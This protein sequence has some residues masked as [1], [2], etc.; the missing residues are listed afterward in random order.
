MSYEKNRSAAI[1]GVICGF[2]LSVFFNNYAPGVLGNETILYTAYPN[3]K[4]GFEIPFLINMGWSFFF[5]TALMILISF[6]G[7]KIN[8]KAFVFDK[9]MFAIS[10]SVLVLIV[11]KKYYSANSQQ[12]SDRQ[13]EP[14]K[15]TDNYTSLVAYEISSDRIKYF[16]L[17]RI[18][19]VQV[20]NQSMSNE[21][22]HE[23]VKPD[24]FGFGEKEK[25][26]ELIMKM[27][28]RA[29]LFLKDEYPMTISYTK[30]DKKSGDYILKTIVYSLVP[31][32]RFAKGLPGEIEFL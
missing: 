15:F 27:S 12:I 14:I 21:S 13:V 31:A 19:D 30:K 5:T 4:G 17:E 16:N 20:R 28:L 11:L 18:T 7:P 24:V 25:S 26:Y 1:A 9:G 3:G 29:W 10:K 22:K 6:S 32:K 23:D 8:P 2:V